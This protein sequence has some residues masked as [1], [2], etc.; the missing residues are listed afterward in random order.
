MAK[1]AKTEVVKT[2]DTFSEVSAMVGQMSSFLAVGRSTFEAAT[3]RLEQ[4]E[5]IARQA[6]D[7]NNTASIGEQYDKLKNGMTAYIKAIGD[8]STIVPPVKG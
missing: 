5:T 6:L 1:T 4:V 3:A 2:V 7:A 8:L